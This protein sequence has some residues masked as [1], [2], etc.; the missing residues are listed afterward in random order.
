[1][2][3]PVLVLDTHVVLDIFVFQDPAVD[4]LRD[5]LLQRH[6]L[7]LATLAMRDELK[8]VLD[9]PRIAA[10]MS[11]RGLLPDRLLPEI[12]QVMVLH[13]EAAPAKVRCRDADDQKFID[14]ALA[15]GACLLSRDREVLCLAKPLLALGVNVSASFCRARP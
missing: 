14:L 12:D 10:R 6:V 4:A 13:P 3:V 1:M 15:H 8:R 7:W 2:G 5:G 11:Q 9:Y